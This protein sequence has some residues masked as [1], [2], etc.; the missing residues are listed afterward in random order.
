MKK[1]KKMN[2]LLGTL[3]ATVALSHAVDSYS[4]VVGYSKGSFS[5]GTTGQSVGFVKAAVFT[6]SASKLSNSSLSAS[7][8]TA[9]NN[10]LAPV[11]GLP[12]HYVEIT[13]GAN[14]GLN[15]DIISN[16]GT[17]VVV[18]GDLSNV[19]ATE[20]I[21]IRPHVKASNVFAGNTDLADFTD[22]LQVFNADG[23]S[24]SLLRDSSQPSGWVDISTFAQAD[25]VIY[26]G[27]A[28][29][30]STAGSGQY[31]F[32]GVVKSNATVVPLY[33]ASLNYVSPGN[34]SANP[35]IQTSNLGANLGEYVDTVGT[36]SA[37]GNFIQNR[38]V[39][40]AGA[41]DKFIDVDTFST[42]SG[43]NI[44]GGG[45]V[46]VSVAADTTWKVPAPYTK[47]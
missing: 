22:T 10:S 31:T 3:L 33:A 20:Q 30:L 38:V 27:Q 39:L 2:L 34:P 24:T 41:T 23:S 13:S 1:M 11:G 6:G 4:D 42:A 26:P 16:T 29:L 36:F 46:L 32:T 43:V 15:A 9:A 44:P 21:V 25:V 17:T 18:D 14:E 7:G 35:D 12:T 19:G 5:A 37:D 40:W 28:F 47:P 45:A 8:L